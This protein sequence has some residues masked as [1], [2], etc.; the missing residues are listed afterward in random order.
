MKNKGSVKL[1]THDK[2]KS[3]ITLIT[4]AQPK[5]NI[6]A[7]FLFLAGSF[8]TATAN[9]TSF[10]ATYSVGFVDVFMN[11]VKL[12]DSSYT[13]TNGTTIVLSEGAS[14]GDVIEIIGYVITTP[15]YNITV[16]TSSPSGGANGD[17]W[18]KYTA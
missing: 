10:S 11:G 1:I 17:I 16:S 7:V 5:P 9:Q 6:L 12:S 2:V 15:T 4:K 13:A 8:A 3:I 18:I 14:L